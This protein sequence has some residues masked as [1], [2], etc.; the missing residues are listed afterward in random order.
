MSDHVVPVRTYLLVFLALM[1]GTFLTVYV[2]RHDLGAFNTP[3][4]LG[5]AIVKAT[6]VVLFFMHVKYSPRLTQLVAASGFAFLA[7]LFAIMLMDY[8]ARGTVNP[9]TRSN[10]AFQI[11]DK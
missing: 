8:A 3:I 7:M 10:Q 5:I 2:A 6:L 9:E 4:A 1:L 11:E